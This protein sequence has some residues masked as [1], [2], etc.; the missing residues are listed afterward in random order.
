MDQWILC[1]RDYSYFETKGVSIYLRN[2][3]W[4]RRGLDISHG[5][6]DISQD[7]FDRGGRALA[8]A[9][10]DGGVA[11]EVYDNIF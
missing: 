1:A 11:I 7:I 4:R 10:T 9:R 5:L 2:S 6:C 3:E 8:Q